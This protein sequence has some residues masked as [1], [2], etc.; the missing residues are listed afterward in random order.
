MVARLAAEHDVDL[1]RIKGTGQ[2]GRIT[3]KDVK[4]FISE[5]AP[6][7]TPVGGTNK[8]WTPMRQAI[9]EHMV[10]SKHTSAH[11]TTVFEVDMSAV[12][13]HH[14]EHK[15]Q[16]D[17]DGSKL[18]L[19]AYFVAASAAALQDHPILNSTLLE[20]KIVLKDDVNIGV[21]VSLGENGLIVPV[22]KHAARKPLVET[23]REL[24]DLVA[25]ARAQQLQPDEVQDGTFTITNHGVSGSLFAT[26]IINQ[27]QCAIM[28]I[29]AVQKRPV[30]EHDAIVVR[31]MAYLTLSF[32]HRIIDGAIANTFLAK[33]KSVLESWA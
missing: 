33:V 23:A 31:P 13:G 18:T 8:P 26:A 7:T 27:P 1:K 5:N 24:N 17:R 2:G 10:R 9:A 28:G 6:D 12:V 21:A 22:I 14:Q 29:G 30:V 20:D 15:A 4:R 19:T 25:R 16:L 32:D 3:K 11:V